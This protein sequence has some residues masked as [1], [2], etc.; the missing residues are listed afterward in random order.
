MPWHQFWKRSTG[1]PEPST[2]PANTATAQS[3]PPHMQRVVEERR[4]PETGAP[5]PKTR[6]DRLER[7]RMTI[8]FDIE[9]GELAAAP[10][11]PWRQRIA[12]L[13]DAMA[14]V[15]EDIARSSKVQPSPFVS[16][17]PTPVTNIEIAAESTASIGFDVGG[18]SFAYSEDLD[19]AERGHQVAQSE[20]ILRRGS[21]EPLI[22]TGIG[23]DLAELLRQH[24]DE[25]LF[26]FA[27][28]L[29][30]RVLDQEP[31]PDNVTLDQMVP[32][33]PVCGGWM[34]W[35]GRC[36]ACRNRE[37]ALQ[38]LLREE[39]RLLSERAREAEEQHRLTERLSIARRKLKD[40]DAEIEQV[41]AHM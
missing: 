15:Q 31:V 29:R 23:P 36:Q 6:L 19:W 32:P 7:N 8:L 33:C 41:R 12:L 17:P 40:I 16:L 27:S 22:P 2:E 28:D 14:T 24:L 26:V 10:D 9:Q 21:V 18:E 34:D 37:V 1:E 5:D 38:T 3:L 4:R 11:N 25:S 20:L 35:K 39:N 13:T 30:D